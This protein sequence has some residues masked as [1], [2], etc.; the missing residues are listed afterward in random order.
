MSF[1]PPKGWDRESDKLFIHETG[2]RIERREYRQ[3]QGWFLIPVDLAQEVVGFD[4]TPAGRD[5]AFAAFAEGRFDK[6]PRKRKTAAG[7]DPAAA[8]K[9]R[10]PKEDPDE[11]ED[12]EEDST[13][14]ASMDAKEDEG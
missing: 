7:D 3:K 9:G 12:P 6:K 1:K 14:E 10:K 11:D 5:L 8:R 4:P 2:I 13:A